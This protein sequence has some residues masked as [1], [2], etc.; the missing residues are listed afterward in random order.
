MVSAWVRETELVL[1][2]IMLIKDSHHFRPIYNKL[3]LNEKPLTLVPNAVQLY[4]LIQSV[5]N[6][7]TKGNLKELRCIV[8]FQQRRVLQELPMSYSVNLHLKYWSSVFFLSPDINITSHF[9]DEDTT[10]LWL[11]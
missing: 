9:Q 2:K 5:V 7:C 1:A 4:R 6:F 3:F 10:L 11:Q 8:N